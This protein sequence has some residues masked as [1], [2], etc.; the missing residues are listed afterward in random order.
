MGPEVHAI[1]LCIYSLINHIKPL[2]KYG[3]AQLHDLCAGQ[4]GSSVPNEN[5]IDLNT[6]GQ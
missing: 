1:S 6:L 3:V 2:M 5:D 4:I